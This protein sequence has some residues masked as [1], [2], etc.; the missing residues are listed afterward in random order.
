[1]TTSYGRSDRV[2]HYLLVFVR[3][4]K[5]TRLL[6]AIGIIGLAIGLTGAILMALVARTALSF[7]DMIPE[8]ERIYLGISVLSGPGMP[9]DYNQASASGA[10]ALIE[11]NLPN[12][13]A[14]VRLVEADVELR[15]GSSTTRQEIYWTD[16]DFFEVVQ[17]PV[18]HGDP[19]EAL[20]RPS[21]I[22]MT[23]TEAL[24]HFGRENAVG[25]AINVAG[26]PMIVRAVL[27]DFPNDNTDIKNG[28]F[29]SGLATASPIARPATAGDG[30]FA[31]DARTY[32]RLRPGASPEQVERGME[33]LINSLVPEPM[34][35]S[36]AMKL[37]RVDAI[38]LYEGFFPDARQR[39]QI[40][41]LVA[42]LILFIAVANFINLSVALSG[43]RRREIGVRKANGASRTQIATQ[44]LAESIA[45]VLIAILLAIAAVELL[46]PSVN[47]FLD[48]GARFDLF[49]DG[50]LL[51]ALLAATVATGLLAGAYPALLLS[52]S[53]PVAVLKNQVLPERGGALVRNV[54]VTL[55]FAILIG[56]IVAMA[57]V[58]QQRVFA[59][60]EALRADIDQVLTVSA[61]CPT[62]FRQQAAR[63]PGVQ[64]V[65]CSGSELLT[66]AIFGFIELRGERVSADLV[67]MLPS[68]FALLGIVPVAGSLATLPAD[69]EE[70]VSKAVIN[71]EAVRQFGYGSPAA[72]IG[73][74]LPIPPEQ[75]DSPSIQA[76]V[77]AV[78]PDFA[79]YSVETAIKPTI[80]LSRPLY[81]GSEGLVTVKLAGSSI[82][83]TL[84][85][86]DRQWR[87]TGNTTPVERA[88]LD[89]H[90]QKLYEDL[91]RS[92]RLF[93]IFAGV[94]AFLACLG[95]IGLSVSA[96]ERRTKEIGIRKA[97]GAR[98]DQILT[99]LL[100]QLS[101]PV[102]LA[103]LLAWPVA[104]WL[105]QSWLNG[106]AYHVPLHLWLFP[107][108]GLVAVSVA[109][110]SVAGQAFL[111]ARQKPAQALR[112]E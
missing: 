35:G 27:A 106:F 58:Y 109:V 86:I 46:L 23:R 22:V 87:A 16:P 96:A 20:R 39:L 3:N 73:Q 102:L 44:F 108:A 90:V 62:S 111:V 19:S 95:L 52:A 77:V 75:P 80:Y 85:E 84:T 68:N 105:M 40:G 37:V 34:R 61:P 72:A 74:I 92:T 70:V 55:Q 1:V 6:S 11:A 12:V 65:S 100:W 30:S 21:G 17:L 81:P 29:G 107:A 31:I 112:Y 103:N 48:A 2:R 64:G 33:P 14:A 38:N 25:Q 101:R 76:E 32:L 59:T 18:L 4:L 78:V 24:R 97:L 47:A 104:W 67:S 15:R 10:A 8:R 26:D 99:L 56:L 41:S 42:G 36:Y 63:L 93:A 110:L 54:L 50:A 49:G 60:Q 13:E 83:E 51:L 57:V 94:A 66:G 71:E 69:G 89:E 53:P 9:P 7:N 28:I 91:V 45:T 98:T 43:R 82:P 88:F 5:A 79:F